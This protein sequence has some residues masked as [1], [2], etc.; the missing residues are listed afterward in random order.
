MPFGVKNGQPTYQKVVTK[1]LHEYIYA[2]MKIFLDDLAI[3]SDLST[4]LEKLKKCFFKCTKYG[5]SLNLY[6][7]AFMVCFR[8]ILGFIISK[9]GKIL[10]L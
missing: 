5:I 2:F 9:E 3:F 8:T 6:K 4:Y 1:A 7:C 10:D